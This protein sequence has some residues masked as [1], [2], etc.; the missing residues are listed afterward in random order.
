[1]FGFSPF[2]GIKN[3]YYW[4]HIPVFSLAAGSGLT[5]PSRQNSAL[6]QED[7]PVGNLLLLSPHTPPPQQ[8]QVFKTPKNKSTKK[9]HSSRSDSSQDEE[10]PVETILSFSLHTPPTQQFVFRT[11][12]SKS[13]SKR[14]P[15]CSGSSTKKLIEPE[16]AFTTKLVQINASKK[17]L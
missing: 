17:L 6:S 10:V 14:H 8:Q 2:F 11:P 3:W 1:M 15:S 7:V 13:S 12:K 5:P 16:G 4:F 9:R